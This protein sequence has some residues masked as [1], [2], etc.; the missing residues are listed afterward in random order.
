VYTAEQN[1]VRNH[2][3]FLSL[4]DCATAPPVGPLQIRFL[5]QTRLK[6]EGA[7]ARRPEFHVFCRALLRRLSSLALFHCGSRLEVDYRGLIEQARTVRLVRD[8][9]RWTE[10]ARYSS[11]QGRQMTWDGFTGLATYAGD[12]KPFWP[13]LVFGQ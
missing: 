1:L 10:W 2:D 6:H 7:I 11:R 3:V 9:T 8:D 4:K 13:Y 5:T 12:L